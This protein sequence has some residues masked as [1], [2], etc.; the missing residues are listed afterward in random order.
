[1]QTP[2]INTSYAVCI[3]ASIYMQ[4]LFG[5]YENE[6]NTLKGYREQIKGVTD[7]WVNA[8]KEVEKYD[9][10]LIEARTLV[11]DADYR[12][13]RAVRLLAAFLRMQDGGKNNG[14]PLMSAIFSE[15]P[16]KIARKQGQSEIDDLIHIENQLT[17]HAAGKPWQAEQL[18]NIK[19]VREGYQAAIKKRDEINQK[20]AAAVSVRVAAKQDFVTAY[21]EIAARV[22]ADFVNDAEFAE[23]FF[24]DLR[25]LRDTQENKEDPAVVTPAV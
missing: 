17:A 16:S 25:D 7:A 3:A 15:P 22:K 6:H 10:P 9:I 2:L 4:T 19:T 12:A 23:L 8:Q 14:G 11:A 21:R 13:D 1:M 18:Q 24:D 5:A 20:I